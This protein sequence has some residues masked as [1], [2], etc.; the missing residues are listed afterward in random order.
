MKKKLWAFHSWIG[1]YAGLFIGIIS[2][3]GAL[4]VFKFEIDEF[5]NPHLF[6]VKPEVQHQD[7]NKGIENALNLYSDN[8]GYRI[9]VPK[10][11]DESLKVT[12]YLD[13]P[14]SAAKITQEVYIN[15]YTNEVLGERNMY[16][17]FSFFIRNI[18]VR[19][20]EGLYGR[21]WVGFFGL[22]LTISLVMSCFL[23]FDFTKKQKFGEVRTKNK[24]L[25]Y[26]DLHK[27]I[28][29]FTIV[30]QLIIAITGTWLGFQPKLEQP[31]LGHRPG[32][33][34]AS[35][36]PLDKKVDQNKVVD[37]DK[38]LQASKSF[39]PDMIPAMLIPSKDGSNIVRIF[40]DI[41]NTVYER[42]TNFVVVD[43]DNYQFISKLDIRESGP[44][45]HLY[46]MQEALHFGDF[47]G[48]LL[49]I[50]YCLM[51]LIAGFL[52]IS[53]FFIYYK[54]TEKK[55]IKSYPLLTTSNLLWGFVTLSSLWFIIIGYSS[56]TYGATYPTT[57]YTTPLFY[58]LFILYISYRGLL[59]V[60]K[61]YP[62]TKKS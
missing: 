26:A 57:Y 5:L 48:I 21:Q 45:G 35:S 49:K 61:W 58:G 39:F 53:G 59:M 14:V 15:P 25:K 52:S 19:L 47:G 55:R 38:V 50:I 3:T 12:I 34:I 9:D 11:K 10:E 36:F 20:F 33:F 30:L 43:K 27:F 40:G 46:Y 17:S 41:P 32:K 22:L 4:A 54:R 2:V 56:V 42:H 51:G 23:Y 1:L 29:L 31:L 28:G 37:F 7:I 18:H 60:K 24:R 62:E 6:K 8:N 16:K 13:D 44:S